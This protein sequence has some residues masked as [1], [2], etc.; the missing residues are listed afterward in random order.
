MK[1]GRPSK[2][3]EHI[4]VN[5][6]MLARIGLSEKA[7][8]HSVGISPVTMDSWQ[9]KNPEFLNRLKKAR[10]HGKAVLLNSILGHAQRHWQ[11]AAWLLELC[12]P[13]EFGRAQKLELPQ[14]SGAPATFRVV[15]EKKPET[16]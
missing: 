12:F 5:I 11:A 16:V 9:S 8:C 3:D 1:L 15:Y 7:I 2:L 6:E 14:K 10:E 4:I 13:E